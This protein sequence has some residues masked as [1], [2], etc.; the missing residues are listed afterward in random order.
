MRIL[1]LK[2]SALGDVVQALPAVAHL[3][4][5]LPAAEISWLA[6]PEYVPLLE[7][8]APVRRVIPFERERLSIARPLEALGRA[9]VLV[10]TLRALRFHAAI[11]FQG[12]LRTAALALASGAPVR[13]GFRRLRE[14]ASTLYTHPVPV[15]LRAHRLDAHLRLLAPL[16]VRPEDPAIAGGR[17]PPPPLAIAAAA[18]EAV[19]VR[20]LGPAAPPAGTPVVALCPGAALPVKQWPAAAFGRLAAFLIAAR[21]GLRIIILG[22]RA[23]AP[24]GAA[25][26]A[27]AGHGPPA[28]SDLAGRTSV[29]DL[30]ALLRRADVAVAG[31][32]GPLHVA[33]AVGTPTIALF[34]PTDP[35]RVAPRGASHRVVLAGPEAGELPCRPC[36]LRECPLPRR[37][38]LLDLTPERVAAAVRELLPR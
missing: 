27:A 5:S 8:H 17:E 35:R 25:V 20:L 10:R 9:A 24:L 15:P 36:M 22:S 12:L 30:A 31:D 19:A 7:R 1:I 16:G 29:L 13:I 2:P 28:V 34:G 33:W 21:P 23:E 6:R 32:S 11:D 14:G 4:R 26:A 3:A 38:C 18:A 37:A